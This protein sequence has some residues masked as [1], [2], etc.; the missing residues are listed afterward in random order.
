[1]RKLK[2]DLNG[3]RVDSFQTAKTSAE[4][5]TVRGHDATRL[6]DSCGCPIPS[7]GCSIGCP[8]TG[9]ECGPN[10]NNCWTVIEN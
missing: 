2:L 4:H 5:G 3:L 10:S 6:Q 8:V 7:D 9:A 1:M